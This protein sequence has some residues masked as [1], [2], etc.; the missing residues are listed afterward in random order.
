MKAHHRRPNL[1]HGFEVCL[2]KCRGGCNG[3][4]YFPKPEFF[5]IGFQELLG[6]DVALWV[7]RWLLVDK[8]VRI[9]R[10]TGRFV[11]LCTVV[12]NGLDTVHC[13]AQ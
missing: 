10:F 8:K 11:Y 1:Q 12:M 9:V 6:R 13:K 7:V 3:V 4:R 5:V 2:V